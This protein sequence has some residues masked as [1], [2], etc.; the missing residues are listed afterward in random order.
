MKKLIL[1][2]AATVIFTS[3]AFAT[4]IWSSEP[5]RQQAPEHEMQLSMN[6][7]D[8]GE[9]STGHSKGHKKPVNKHHAKHHKCDCDGHH[10]H[11]HCEHDDD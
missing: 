1:L 5:Q 8:Q 3:S 2:G 10:R 9:P 6:D 4:G 11:H 7:A